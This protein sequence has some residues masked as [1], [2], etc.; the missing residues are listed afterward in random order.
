MPTNRQSLPPP[1]RQ[2]RKRVIAAIVQESPGGRLYGRTRLFKA[3]WLAHLYFWREWEGLLTTSHGMVHMP[4]G[5]G[6]DSHDELLEEMV[7][8]GTISLSTRRSG[9]F[10]EDVFRSKRRVQVDDHARASI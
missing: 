7:Q 4:N 5:P 1:E 8:E 9:P 6:I 2:E 3:Y 10:D